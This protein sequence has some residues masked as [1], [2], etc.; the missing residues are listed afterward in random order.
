MAAASYQSYIA[1]FRTTLTATLSL[2][3]TPCQVRSSASTV[4]HD[5]A[6]YFYGGF[7]RV[8]HVERYSKPEVELQ[9][10][11]ELL[12]EPVLICRN[13]HECA[14]FEASTNSVR[15]SLKVRHAVFNNSG[16]FRSHWLL[17]RPCSRCAS[18]TRWSNGSQQ[19]R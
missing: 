13:A 8:Q 18:G 11:L 12:L 3:D 19:S 15:I 4:L 9:D 10:S 2:Y 6:I 17:I 7:L 1:C 14:L 16:K 5:R